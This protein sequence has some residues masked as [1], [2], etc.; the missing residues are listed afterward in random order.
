MS[1]RVVITGMSV[2]TPLSDTLDG[3]LDALLQGRSAVTRWKRYGGLPIASKIGADL[4]DYDVVA[5]V[6]DWEARLPDESGRRLRK[7]TSRAPWSTRLTLL[8]ALDAFRDA[9]LLN[10]DEPACDSSTAVRTAVIVAGQHVNSNYTHETGLEFSK[11]PDHID[12][13]FP[14]RVLDTDQAASA[15]ELLGCRG[16]NFSAGGACASGNL[17]LRHALDEIRHHGTRRCLIIGPVFDYSPV[18]LHA[19]AL[20]G[21]ISQHG[22]NDAP[23]R[24][25]R[26]FDRQREGFVPAHGG[27]ALVIEDLELAERRAAPIHAEVLGV[28]VDA[29]GNHLPWPWPEGQFGVMHRLLES[30][31]VAPEW[32]DFVS[33][34]ATSTPIGDVSEI[35]SLRRLLGSHAPRVR[36]N[37]PKSI[38]GHTYW[39][40]ATVETVAA[41]LQMRAGRLHPSI[42]I[43]ACDPEV[44]FDV[45]ADGPRSHHVDYLLKPA[46][47]YGGINSAALFKRYE[48]AAG[49]PRGRS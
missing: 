37:A 38:L 26:P 5:K 6:R 8:L 31:A 41:L 11:E 3:F 35:Q 48:H 20:M 23:A 27:A 36:I 32:I 1:T 19:L 49:V 45:C 10:A 18:D 15:A 30:C 25:S 16:P 47:G 17:A 42:N 33:A 44:D 43:D 24:A 28:T 39:S 2:N 13:L 4:S 40:S 7:L 46:F 12:A 9:G 34:H 29:D 21:A 14:L 22:F